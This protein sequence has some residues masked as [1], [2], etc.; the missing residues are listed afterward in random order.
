MPSRWEPKR[1]GTRNANNRNKTNVPRASSRL[2]S[3]V[4]GGNSVAENQSQEKG[5]YDASA[6]GIL[7]FKK[8]SQINDETAK[9]QIQQNLKAQ[10][11]AEP[12]Q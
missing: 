8:A 9:R 1:V 3:D 4:Q 2:A 11:A 6:Y 5:T 7:E 12:G 10:R